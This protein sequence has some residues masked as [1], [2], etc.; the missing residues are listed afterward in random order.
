MKVWYVQKTDK[1]NRG[2]VSYAI[3]PGLDSIDAEQIMYGFSPGKAYTATSILR[4]GNFLQWGYARSPKNMTEAGR[5]LFINCIVHISKFDGKRPFVTNKCLAPDTLI[6]YIGYRVTSS[7]SLD[8]YCPKDI[9]DKHSPSELIREYKVNKKFIYLEDSLYHIDYELKSLGFKNNSD[10]ANLDRF[11][12]MF[13]STD[14]AAIGQNMLKRYT[15][16]DFSSPSEAKQWL[17][18]NRE[19]LLFIPRCDYKFVILP[20]KIK[21]LL[22]K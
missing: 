21:T 9:I 2:T 14:K 18:T 17:D 3:E 8:R 11:I 20:D 7:R 12:E 22:G 13:D 6:Q 4:H 16:K 10:L 1:G 15:G 5:Q 19:Y